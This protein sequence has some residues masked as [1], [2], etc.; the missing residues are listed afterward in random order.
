MVKLGRKSEFRAAGRVGSVPT[1]QPLPV[2]AWCPVAYGPEPEQKLMVCERAWTERLGEISP[3]SLAREGFSSMRE[4][5]D[6]WRKHRAGGRKA[7]K[8]LLQVAV[9]RVRPWTEDDLELCGAT[10]VEY[11][12]EQHLES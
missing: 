9:Y 2:V 8:P 6:Y 5:R 1:I 11:L 10:I 7:Y 3:E 12:Y 4:F